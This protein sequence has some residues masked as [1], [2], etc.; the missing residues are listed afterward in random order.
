MRKVLIAE[1]YAQ[2]LCRTTEDHQE[3][4]KAFLEKREPQYKGK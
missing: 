2:N 1:S 3:S 4:V